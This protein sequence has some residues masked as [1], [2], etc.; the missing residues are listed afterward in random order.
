[1]NHILVWF[2]GSSTTGIQSAIA[3][4]TKV[5]LDVKWVC[6]EESASNYHDFNL[7]S[8]WSARLDTFNAQ[9]AQYSDH[10]AALTPLDEPYWHEVEK[11]EVEVVIAKLRADWPGKPI[12]L[13]LYKLAWGGTDLR[14]SSHPGYPAGVDWL[15]F[16]TF[17]GS[18]SYSEYLTYLN[19][20]KSIRQSGQKILLNIPNLN[21][22]GSDS[23]LAGWSWDIY[24]VMKN[25]DAIIGA[26]IWLSDT[27]RIAAY[28][29]EPPL[30]QNKA[31]LE[32]IGHAITGK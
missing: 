18:F 16:N 28:P 5:M 24:N 4:G 13:N 17:N 12:Y 20:L 3:N 2:G 30:P 6:F 8:D 9:Y 31:A 22:E 32:L 19:Y 10:I 21:S 25:D 23:Q 7:R 27:Y 11:W 1:M 14:S 15:G 29:T 26:L